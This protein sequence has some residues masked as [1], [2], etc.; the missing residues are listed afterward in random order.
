MEVPVRVS[1]KCKKVIGDTQCYLCEDEG[2]FQ[3][4]VPL[5]STKVE[6]A[7]LYGG[8]LKLLVVCPNQVKTAVK[9]YKKKREKLF[10]ARPVDKAMAD[11]A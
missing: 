1:C 8:S 6:E 9:H 11:N 10:K 3:V 5:C 2:R 7:G 4:W